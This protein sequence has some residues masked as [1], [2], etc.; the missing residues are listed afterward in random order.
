[1]NRTGDPKKFLSS[2]REVKIPFV[3]ADVNPAPDSTKQS[4]VKCSF[5]ILMWQMIK[6]APL[7]ITAE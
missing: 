5:A 4:L 3:P 7:E 2:D 6:E 1:M